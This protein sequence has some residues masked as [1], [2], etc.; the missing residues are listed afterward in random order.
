M[1]HEARTA[2]ICLKEALT[3][4]SSNASSAAPDRPCEEPV[5]TSQKESTVKEPTPWPHSYSYSLSTLLELGF[6]AERS[7]PLLA[8]C[9]VNW[10]VV[11]KMLLRQERATCSVVKKQEEDDWVHLVL[12]KGYQ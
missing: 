11:V 5:S 3:E 1:I 8:Q 10:K 7:I 9:E 4:V 6:V 12:Y 2:A